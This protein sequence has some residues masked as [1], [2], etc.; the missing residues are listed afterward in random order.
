MPNN[1]DSLAV[2]KQPGDDALRRGDESPRL[3][4]P[5]RWVLPLIAAAA[6][7]GAYRV[8]QTW[9]TIML[10]NGPHLHASQ[11][12]LVSVTDAAIMAALAPI[13]L[14]T[15]RAFPIGPPAWLR[16][17]A[18]H[19]VVAFGVAV[20]WVAGL[21]VAFALVTHTPLAMSPDALSMS[22]LTS[23][24][25]AYALLVAV[26]HA[27]AFQRRLRD[28]ELHAARLQAQLT[29]AR[30][31]TLRAQLHPHF[32]FNT[33]HT[34][35]ELIH[36]DPPAADT[37]VIRLARL[38]RVSLD[39]TAAAEV[40]LRRELEVLS[41][42]FDLQQ[43]RMGDRLRVEID[44]DPLLLGALVPPMLLQPLVENALRHGLA[45][46]AASGTVRVSARGGNGCLELCVEDDGVGLAPALREGVGLTNTRTRLAELYGAHQ[47]VVLESRVG[48]GTVV[49]VELPLRR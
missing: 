22:W 7:Y 4:F 17:T 43:A 18:V 37:M 21:L 11:R 42:Y 3:E 36:L 47:R 27:L 16:H 9:F 39:F 49:L 14:W 31:E 45:P 41:T 20:L 23:N 46:R 6:V 44:A 33:L 12:V 35:S 10:F 15:S 32:L 25:F 28:R 29:T 34:I 48:G 2:R 19:V 38:L 40:P 5:R 8:A 1:R 13:A 24:L 26:L 30:L